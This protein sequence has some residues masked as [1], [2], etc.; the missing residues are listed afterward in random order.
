[1]E[2]KQV[3]AAYVFTLAK[4]ERGK[5]ATGMVLAAFGSVLSLIPYIASSCGIRSVYENKAPFYGND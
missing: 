1:M 2:D 5:L 4:A 3:G